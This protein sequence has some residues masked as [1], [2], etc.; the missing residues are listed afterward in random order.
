[1]ITRTKAFLSLLLMLS[2]VC[3]FPTLLFAG[4]QPW[5]SGHNVTG[6]GGPGGSGPPG[7]S[8]GG[9]GGDPVS[10]AFGNLAYGD[11][12]FYIP[13]LGLNLQIYRFYNSQERYVGPFGNHWHF[14]PFMNLV[15][16][17]REI[18]DGTTTR[19]ER[20]V[21]I[22][23]GDGVRLVFVQNDDDTYT[24][25]AGWYYTLEKTADGFAFKEKGGVT[26]RF[27]FSGKLLTTTD[28]NGN[29]MTFAYDDDD[30]LVSITDASSR[31]ILFTYGSNSKVYRII[32]FTGRVW[33][34]RYDDKDNLISV[35]NPL[36]QVKTYA[37]DALSRLISVVNPDGVSLLQQTYDDKNRVLTQ[38]YRKGT[39]TFVYSEGSTRITNRRG[40]DTTVTY[41]LNGNITRMSDPSGYALDQVYDPQFNL[42]GLSD[43]DGMTTFAYD[44]HRNIVSYQRPS[45]ARTTYVYDPAWDQITSVTDPMLHMTNYTYDGKGNLTRMTDALGQETLYEYDAKGKLTKVTLPDGTETTFTGSAQGYLTSITDKVGTDLYTATFE[46]DALGN[47]TAIHRPDGSVV[48]QGYSLLG[49]LTQFTDASFTPPRTY[50]WSYNGGGL[51]TR[52]I[53]NGS[54]KTFEYDNLRLAKINYPGGA[55]TQYTYSENDLFASVTSALGTTQYSYSSTDRI[56]SI[57]HPEGSA[58]TLTYTNDY[59]TRIQGSGKDLKYFYNQDRQL[60]KIQ[61]AVVGKEYSFDYNQDG[62]RKEM[63]DAGG[64][65]TYTYDA[66]DRLVSMLDPA[67]ITITFPA[68]VSKRTATP[69]NDLITAYNLNETNRF[70]HLVTARNSDILANYSYQRPEV[71]LQVKTVQAE[72]RWRAWIAEEPWDTKGMY[73]VFSPLELLK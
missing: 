61:D 18:G 14:I 44:S 9:G 16:V 57:T 67:G 3:F 38:S 71:R 40:F 45:S 33:T 63:T 10:L 73:R 43:G 23:R 6:S 42:V 27:D 51:V 55:S 68:P 41:N 36:D 28:R 20:Q 72:K 5:D 54:D 49:Q 19:I 17:R 59:L 60:T 69:L 13:G 7:G 2:F 32:D 50:T 24:P 30:K 39:F 70:I 15:R 12:D 4:D 11:L 53:E 58:L 48:A 1:M 25:P 29:S 56:T 31:R 34:Y 66:L 26:H 52:M 8:G 37:Y 64:K 35:I 62:N 46:Y 21:I 65:T 22:K 47:L